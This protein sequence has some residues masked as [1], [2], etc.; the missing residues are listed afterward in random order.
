MSLLCATISLQ[1]H[2]EGRSACR[3]RSVPFRGR[4]SDPEVRNGETD[5][6]LGHPCGWIGVD[7]GDAD[8]DFGYLSC[9][10]DH[11]CAGKDESAAR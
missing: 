6:E 5:R 7:D 4:E 10:N 9:S 1:D 2:S 3:G 11:S 8:R